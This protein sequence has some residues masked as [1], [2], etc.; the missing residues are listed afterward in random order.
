MPTP[1]EKA[2]F[3]IPLAK[4]NIPFVLDVFKC[5][6]DA[7]INFDSDTICEVGRQYWIKV[8]KVAQK[9]ALE[10][11]SYTA[12]CGCLDFNIDTTENGIEITH[13]ERLDID[14]S[15]TFTRIILEHFD[16][17]LF[18]YFEYQNNLSP[19][20]RNLFRCNSVAIT[21]YAV[22]TTSFSRWS[23]DLKQKFED[24]LARQ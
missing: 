19:T 23:N 15:T 3:T 22:E 14:T 10:L 8:Y 18:I 12:F 9:I 17:D 24:T 6:E 16:S 13:N 21:K 7:R 11:E 4:E 5:A 2:S 1:T 20:G